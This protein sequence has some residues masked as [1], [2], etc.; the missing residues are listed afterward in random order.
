[1]FVASYSAWAVF[2][3]FLRLTMDS[4]VRIAAVISFRSRSEMAVS[5]I[6]GCYDGFDGFLVRRGCG[7]INEALVE[8][9]A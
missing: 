2:D 5:F 1:M 4:L 6:L 8:R 7:S 9:K 3:C